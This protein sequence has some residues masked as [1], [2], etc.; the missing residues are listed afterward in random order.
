[1]WKYIP[2]VAI[3]ICLLAAVSFSAQQMNEPDSPCFNVGVTYDAVECLLKAKES[4][5]AA[6]NSIYQEIRKRLEGDDAKRLVETERLWIQYRDANCEAER[7]LYEPGTAAQPAYLACIEAM[8]RARTKELRITY[9]V[10]L[11]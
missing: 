2:V 3:S 8:T 1:M 11:K 5:D 6:L 9:T 7:A 10:R 4:S